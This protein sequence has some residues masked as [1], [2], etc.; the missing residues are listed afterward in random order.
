VDAQG[1]GEGLDRAEQ[2]FLKRRHDEHRGRLLRP[3]GAGEPLLSKSTVFLEQLGQAQVGRV[4]RQAVDDDLDDVA[5]RK[6]AGADLAEVALEAAHHDGVEQLRA[7]DR[8]AAAEAQRVEHL[9][10]RREA[11]RMAVVRRRRQEQFMLE[12]GREVAHQ[13][14]QVRVDGVLAGRG[15]GGVVGLVEDQ[16]RAAG[17]VAEPVA[18]RPGV[19]LVADDGVRDDEPR[20]G[21]PRVDAV[22]ALAA[23]RGD[24]VAVVDDEREAKAALHLLAPLAHDRR[25][26][27]DDDAAD[28][29]PHEHLAKDKAGL[30]RLAEPDVVGDEEAD[31][32]HQERFA[33]RLELVV[34]D[35]DP[36]AVGRLEEL[37]VG[38]GDAVPP[39]RVQVGREL[40]RVVEPA[41]GDGL[42]R[43][44]AEHAR[45]DLA[46]PQH[47]ELVALRVVVQARKAHERGVDRPRRRDDLLDEVLPRADVDD[48]AGLELFHYGFGSAF[49][50]S[51]FARSET[52]ESA[53]TSSS[54][55]QS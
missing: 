18:K 51:R 23:A 38:G 41:T 1:A 42:P 2:P 52:S 20:V 19:L 14:R 39:D 33:K 37:G 15:G 50:A 32:R 9:E 54:R 13:P 55:A 30:D 44:R 53:I 5:L 22:A 10:Q 21:R 46:L 49:V 45:V 43:R 6:V 35:L 17:E 12:P 40:P 47:F 27:R 36:G 24:V 26:A 29:L 31:A 3:T 8:D 48:L 28:L 16:H 25:R 7:L 34:L 11:V 4:G